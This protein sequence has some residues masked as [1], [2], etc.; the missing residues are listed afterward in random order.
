MSQI[1]KLIENYANFI[2]IP[3]NTSDAPSQRV[4]FCVYNQRDQLKLEA[5][6]SE[7]EIKTK[8]ANRKWL[9]YDIAN[10]YPQ[11]LIT[12]KY[13][14]K[15]Y[16]KPELTSI[17]ADQFIEYLASGLKQY[18][19]EHETD[20]NT[21]LA[22]NGVGSLFS[23]LKVNSLVEKIAPMH[24]GRLLVFFPG[25]YNSK[26]IHQNYKLLDGYDGWNYHAVA[27]TADGGF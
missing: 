3:F 16:K 23:V 8:D 15:Y 7:F 12:Q 19:S 6:I 27:I 9:F 21:V 18:L 11:F 26:N 10:T 24:L 13:I 5:K 17:N 20:D 1:D 4:I 25:S 2:K 14:E 22:I